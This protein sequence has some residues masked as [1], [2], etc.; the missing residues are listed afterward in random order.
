[1]SASLQF[2]QRDSQPDQE[3]YARSLRLTRSLCWV[4]FFASLAGLFVIG[5]TTK[6]GAWSLFS[7][8]THLLAMAAYQ[9]GLACLKRGSH[10]A[11]KVTL[12]ATAVAQLAIYTYWTGT[13]TCVHIFL[14]LPFV[15]ARLIFL[16]GRVEMILRQ[17]LLAACPA[18]FI[19]LELAFSI[20]GVTPIFPAVEPLARTLLISF[21]VLTTMGTVSLTLFLYSRAE[22]QYQRL[23][24]ENRRQAENI[25]L[26]MVPEPIAA[27]LRSGERL[28]ADRYDDVTILFADLS[29]F[30]TFATYISPERLVGFLNELFSHFDALADQWGVEKIKTI[31]D[32]YML[33]SGLPKPCADHA[34]RAAEAALH[35]QRITEQWAKQNNLPLGLRIGLHSGPV[36]AG[37]I[38]TRKIAYDLWGSSV[39][40]ASRMEGISAPG[41]ITL[42]EE[43]YK[44]IADR[45]HCTERRALHVK[46]L[47]QTSTYLL[48]ERKTTASVIPDLEKSAR[49]G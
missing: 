48:L 32:S 36:V 18:L 29:N 9:S 37:V 30:T 28:I 46:G 10:I 41:E 6:G 1:M 7:L 4:G 19:T 38:G 35:M 5:L 45:F 47:G 24:E 11:A 23:I 31:G 2:S 21:N 22:T 33:V 17:I 3:A 42:S 14:F 15:A 44:R 43:C 13:G 12:M 26:N 39:N 8:V 49:V 16:Q 40:I 25:L 27:R 20:W 34:V